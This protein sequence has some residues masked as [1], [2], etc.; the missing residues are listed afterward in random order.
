MDIIAVGKDQ[1]YNLYVCIFLVHFR[2]ENGRQVVSVV[3]LDILISHRKVK[4][5]IFSFRI[6]LN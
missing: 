3:E 5:L 1:V 6:K 4:T 2:L